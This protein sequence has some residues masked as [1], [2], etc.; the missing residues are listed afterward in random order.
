MSSLAIAIAGST[1][2][3]KNRSKVRQAVAERIK[4]ELTAYA[5]KFP[6]CDL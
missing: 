2:R 3:R 4:A 1:V 5:F 6:G